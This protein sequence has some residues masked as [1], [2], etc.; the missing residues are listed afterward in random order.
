[1]IWWE[2]EIYIKLIIDYQEQKKHE[3]LAKNYNLG[4]G[5]GI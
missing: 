1:M 4:K 5:I 3:E 2:R